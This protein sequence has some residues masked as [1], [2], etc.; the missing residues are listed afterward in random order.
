MFKQQN[1]LTNQGDNENSNEQVNTLNT[2]KPQETEVS[3]GNL[4]FY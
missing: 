4:S 3:T 1:R 2:E